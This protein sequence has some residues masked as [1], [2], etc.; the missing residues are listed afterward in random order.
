MWGALA[1]SSPPIHICFGCGGR[2]PRLDEAPC[3]RC[4]EPAVKVLWLP[5]EQRGPASGV[6]A[7][8]SVAA[9]GILLALGVLYGGAVAGLA[10]AALREGGS[11]AAA[12]P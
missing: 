3:R 5:G 11:P 6:E 2:R 4:G 10:S 7:A 8:L 1:S 12:P 9:S